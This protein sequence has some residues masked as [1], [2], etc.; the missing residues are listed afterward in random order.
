MIRSIQCVVLLSIWDS[1]KMTKIN[2]KKMVKSWFFVSDRRMISLCY[3]IEEDIVTE[4]KS[5]TMRTKLYITPACLAG[6][7]NFYF[8]IIILFSLFILFK[9]LKK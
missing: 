5:Y 1:N 2:D 6:L 8:L 9:K 7:F 4:G 3:L